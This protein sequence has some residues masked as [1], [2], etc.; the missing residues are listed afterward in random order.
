MTE[1]RCAVIYLVRKVDANRWMPRFLR[2]IKTHTPGMNYDLVII[3]K[4]YAEG[5]VPSYLRSFSAPGLDH[6]VTITFRD[7][8]FATEAFFA[9]AERL[10]HVALLFFVSSAQVL[11]PGWVSKM[12]QPLLRGH[13]QLVGASAGFERLN[14]EAPFP[15]PSIRTTGFSM[16]RRDW[17]ALERG[18]LSVRYGGNLFEAGP[19]SMTKQVLRRGGKVLIAGRNGQTYDLDNWLN[20]ATFR[21]SSQENLL[22]SDKRTDQFALARPKKRRQLAVANWGE[23]VEVLP[24]STVLVYMKRILAVMRRLLWQTIGRWLILL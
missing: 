18:D 9:A 6:L 5:E 10:D 13:A 19:H 21:L 2:S 3:L 24:V 15:N 4:G 1:N 16:L 11:A 22:F 8:R 14:N 7:D 20:S 12:F 23:E 17:L